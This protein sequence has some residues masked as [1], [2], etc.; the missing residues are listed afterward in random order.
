MVLICRH[1][2]A[3]QKVILL[4]ELCASSAAGGEI[5]VG[6]DVNYLLLSA[7]YGCPL[8][9]QGVGSEAYLN[10]TSQGEPVPPVPS[11]SRGA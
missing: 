2:P 3:N 6:N 8:Q 9:P 1:L 4:C 7:V 11:L 10:S 5:F